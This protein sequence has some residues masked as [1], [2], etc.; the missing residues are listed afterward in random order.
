M[1][2]HF[3]FT[4]LYRFR[5]HFCQQLMDKGCS[6]VSR[7]CSSLPPLMVGESSKFNF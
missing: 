4:S 1:K 2:I 3:I 6:L 5:R 7:V